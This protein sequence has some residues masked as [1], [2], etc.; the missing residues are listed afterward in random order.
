M[1][2][3]ELHPPIPLVEIVAAA[4]DDLTPS[5]RRLALLITD[6]PTA[7]AFATVADTAARVD[8]SG[9]TVV[10][11]ATKLGF[12]GYGG[13]QD[14]ARRSLEAQLRRPTDRLRRDTPQDDAMSDHSW[15]QRRAAAVGSVEAVFQSVTPE[16]IRALATP[17]ATADGGV[18]IVSS[19]VSS[20]VASLLAAELSL[21][22]PRVRRLRGSGAALA[23]E[24]IDAA[25]G[26]VVVAI[27]TPRYEN[28]VVDTVQ[29]LSDEGVVVVAITD[30]PLSPLAALA[31]TWCQ[32]GV[33][34][35]G[36]FDSALPT[37]TLI[38]LVVAD[39]AVQLRGP[40]A[41]RLD[42]AE[43]LWSLNGV[44]VDE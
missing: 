29:F 31:D 6:D 40:A 8:V 10:R 33:R 32:V 25:P 24:L 19:D 44:F 14:H 37:L 15:D 2:A 43:T 3:T 36:P 41:S 26:D 5:E 1:S 12:D 23:A 39:V 30:G 16:K 38:E 11:F 35:T 9:P 21:L 34:A 7:L 27:D 28:R 42:R 22:R 20:P 18:W 4:S 17:I 13:L